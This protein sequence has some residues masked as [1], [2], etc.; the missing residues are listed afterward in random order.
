[1]IVR[2]PDSLTPLSATGTK[3]AKA[4]FTAPPV[5]EDAQFQG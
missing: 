4:A 5:I 2:Y 1:M 3:C